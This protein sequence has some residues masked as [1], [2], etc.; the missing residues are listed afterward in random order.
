MSVP[1]LRDFVIDVSSNPDLAMRFAADPTAALE[2]V[3]LTDE[4]KAALLARDSAQ[5]RRL[6][7][8]KLNGSNQSNGMKKKKTTKKKKKKK[9]KPARKRKS[10]GK[11]ASRIAHA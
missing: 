11:K 6:M 8:A 9:R 10:P 7:G 4:E 1:A 3:E 2:R 5:L